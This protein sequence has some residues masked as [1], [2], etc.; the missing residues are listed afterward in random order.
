MT[1]RP[2]LNVDL[3]E[4]PGEP[5]ELFGLAHRVNVA[6]GGHAGDPAS[7]RAACRQAQLS[8]ALVGA[9]PS[10]PDRE[11]FGRAEMLIVPGMLRM[12]LEKQCRDLATIARELGVRVAHL[13][14][15]GAL[16][17]AADRDPLLAE[18]VVEA[19]RSALGEVAIVGPPEGEL[20]RAALRAGVP[21]LAEGFADR[22]YDRDGQL[23]PRG[24]PGSLIEDPAAAAA[25]AIRL[26]KEDRFHSICVHSDT[27]NA[28]LIARAVRAALDGS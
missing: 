26:A 11:H 1:A 16:Y 18:V 24:S 23:I 21:F 25:Q 14:P 4:L 3:G 13:K 9:H 28:I 2:D 27:P 7:M 20:G 17:R 12:S 15:H 6:C 22:G 19:S 10:Y 8:G 5:V